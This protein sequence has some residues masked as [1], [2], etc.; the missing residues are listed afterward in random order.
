MIFNILSLHLKLIKFESCLPWQMICPTPPKKK[1]KFHLSTL[2]STQLDKLHIMLLSEKQYHKQYL[3]KRLFGHFY[4]NVFPIV[5]SWHIYTY[6]PSE[7]NTPTN[8]VAWNEAWFESLLF[9]EYRRHDCGV[10][11]QDSK[12]ARRMKVNY[13]WPDVFALGKI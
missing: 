9:G 3:I 8:M 10:A 6:N 13:V 4:G 2:I 5:D 7:K 12:D 11:W 1:R